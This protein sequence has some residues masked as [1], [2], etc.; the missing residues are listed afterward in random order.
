M[1]ILGLALALWMTGCG[2]QP[3]AHYAKSVLGDS[4]STEVHILMEDPQNTVLIKDAV[5]RAVITK[6][7]T[8]LVPKAASESHLDVRVS[9]VSFTPLRYDTD[10]YIVTYR[11][12]VALAIVHQRQN[13]Q[14]NYNTRGVYDFDIEPNAIISDQ[15]RFEAISQGASKALDAFIAQLSAQGLSRPKE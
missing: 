12:T 14:K 9:G 6:L 1:R 11:T 10:G 15:A 7:R 3:A 5:D 4:V 13:Q 2:Y 8:S